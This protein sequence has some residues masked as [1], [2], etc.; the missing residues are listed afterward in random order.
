MAIT[1]TKGKNMY[2]SIIKLKRSLGDKADLI[3]SGVKDRHLREIIKNSTHIIYSYIK[4]IAKLPIEQ[5]NAILDQIC[6]SLSKAEI[7]R[8]FASNDI[9]KDTSDQ[10]T[11]AYNTLEKIQQK[12]VIITLSTENT[13][14]KFTAK[15]QIFNTYL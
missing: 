14:T 6:V 15:K 2:T 10:E 4:T 3:L 12:K 9:P 11:K 8:R 13:D 1:K 7:Y 5:S